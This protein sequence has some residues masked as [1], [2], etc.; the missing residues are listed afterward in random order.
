MIYCGKIDEYVDQNRKCVKTKC[1]YYIEKEDSCIYPE[2]STEDF[3][4]GLHD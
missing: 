3:S 2:P 1:K 4:R